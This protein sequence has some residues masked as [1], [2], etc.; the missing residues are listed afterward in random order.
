VLDGIS[1]VLEVALIRY[2]VQLVRHPGPAPLD[3][4]LATDDDV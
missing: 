2:L 3:G 1:V 4:V